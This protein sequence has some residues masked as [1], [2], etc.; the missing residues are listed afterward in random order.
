MSI[1]SEIRYRSI[2]YENSQIH[3]YLFNS[4]FQN[5]LDFPVF[6][7]RMFDFPFPFL[8]K[9]SFGAMSYNFYFISGGKN[10]ASVLNSLQQHQPD[11]RPR[12]VLQL[13]DRTPPATNPPQVTPP[14]AV[15][16]TEANL[17]R[18]TTPAP[19]PR[20]QEILH[21]RAQSVHGSVSHRSQY[22]RRSRSR[23]RRNSRSPRRSSQGG[24]N[25][26]E[27]PLLEGPPG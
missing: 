25:T 3:E 22:S 15:P 21:Q 10:T 4:I 2:F 19:R 5:P 13:L 18:G 12:P 11:A 1:Y 17:A 20:N 23:R 9:V 24:R 7:K 14:E 16:L 8:V 6:P 27:P 26:P